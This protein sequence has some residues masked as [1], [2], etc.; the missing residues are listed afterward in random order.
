MTLDT[1]NPSGTVAWQKLRTH[2]EKME[3]VSIK[4]MFSNDNKRVEK[5]NIEWQDFII[6]YSKNK[7]SEETIAILIELAEEVGLKSAIESYFSGEAINQTENRAVLHTALRANENDVVLVDGV[8]VI[9]E[10]YKVKKDIEVFTNV[11]VNC[12]RK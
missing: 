3:Y 10:I 9:P 11:I 12:T 6:D 5:F 7:I 8:N 4:E 2:F 1:T